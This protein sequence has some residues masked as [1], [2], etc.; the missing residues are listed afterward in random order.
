MTTDASSANPTWTLVERNLSSFSARATTIAEFD[1]ET[2]YFVGTARGLYSSPDPLTTDWL[3][4]APND[5]GLAVISALRYRTA[6]SKVLIGTHGNGMWEAIVDETFSVGDIAAQDFKVF[7]N[8]VQNN[9]FTIQAVALRNTSAKIT[10]YSL[11]GQRVFQ[12]NIE[13]ND[14]GLLLVEPMQQIS[15]GQYILKIE[16]ANKSYATQI[17]IK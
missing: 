6:D 2:K 12:D 9:A 13:A 17:L 11:N 15:A 5:I 10:L 4:E 1:G 14:N 3:Q 16:H 8:P 7:P